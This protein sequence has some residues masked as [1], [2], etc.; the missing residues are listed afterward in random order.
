MRKWDDPNVPHEGMVFYAGAWRT[1]TGV[2][3][4]RVR[5]R[6][7]NRRADR[8]DRRAK[9]EAHKARVPR[10]P[11]TREEVFAQSDGRCVYCGAPAT[12]VDHLVSLAHG[13][14]GM[15]GHLFAA[16]SRCNDSKNARDG[17]W[18]DKN[19]PWFWDFWLEEFILPFED[20]AEPRRTKYRCGVLH[21]ASTLGGSAC[22]WRS[23]RREVRALAVAGPDDNPDA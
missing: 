17:E 14:P 16:C 4:Q 19:A 12:E 22:W 1:P 10:G 21:R 6:E 2:E 20:G 8:R 9:R 18:I 7:R 23:C 15:I 13:G 3:R 11:W 5:D